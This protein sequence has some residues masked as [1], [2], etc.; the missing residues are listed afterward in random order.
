[1]TQP[2]HVG[3]I[4]LGAMGAGIARTLRN[5]GF[6]VHVCDVKPGAAEAFAKEGGSAW[7]NPGEVA[8]AAPVVVSVVVNAAQTEGVLFGDN[9]AAAA[10]KPGSTFIMCSTVDPHWSVALESRLAD[11]GLSGITTVG[12]MIAVGLAFLASGW[13]ASAVVLSVL[14]ALAVKLSSRGP[15]FFR[16]KRYGLDGRSIDDAI[17]TMTACLAKFRSDLAGL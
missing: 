15:V 2:Q 8:A 1:M 5:R 12:A 16:Q 3:V 17:S 9:G 10:M 13:A 14:V 7:A 4:G 6:H 11:R